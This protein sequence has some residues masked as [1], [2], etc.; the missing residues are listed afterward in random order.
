MTGASDGVWLVLSHVG[1]CRSAKVSLTPMER[2]SLF[3]S[4]D[5]RQLVSLQL[6][7]PLPPLSLRQIKLQVWLIYRLHVSRFWPGHYRGTSFPL[8]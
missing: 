6:S 1:S 4:L 3:R 5:S 8:V 2:S 7:R